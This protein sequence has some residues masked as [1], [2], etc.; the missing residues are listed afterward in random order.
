MR[1]ILLSL[2]QIVLVSG[3]LYSYYHFFLRNKRFH[4]YNRFF[5][6]AVIALSILIPFLNI[7]VYFTEQEA[8]SYFVLRTLNIVPDNG[9]GEEFT[10]AVILPEESRS[11]NYYMLLYYVYIGLSVL[12]LARI[13]ISLIKIHKLYRNNPVEK[14][15]GAD[16]ETIYFINTVEPGTPF[17]FFKW[18]FWNRDIELQSDKG[19]QIFRHEMFHIRQKHSWDTIF[20]EIAT[21]IFWI[22]PFFHIIKKEIKAIHEFLADKYAANE[23][24][25]W[26]YAELLLMQALHTNHSLVNPFFH[27]QIKRRIAMITSSNKPGHQYLRKILVLPLLALVAALFAFTYKASRNNND[28]NIPKVEGNKLTLVV[29]AGHGGIDAGALSRDGKFHESEITLQ[30]A[31]KIEELSSSYNI[32]VVLTRAQ[33]QLPGNAGNIKDGLV[34]RVQISKESKA[35][36]FLSLHLNAQQSNAKNVLTGFE[37]YIAKQ[38]NGTNSSPLASTV[39]RHLSAMYTTNDIVKVRS[40]DIYVLEHNHAPS[41][42]LE[43]GSITNANDLAFISNEANQEQV[44]KTI[45]AAITAWANTDRKAKPAPLPLMTNK[46]FADTPRATPFLKVLVNKILIKKDEKNEERV[47]AGENIS[48]FPD[49][50]LIINGKKY[51]PQDAAK[52]K[53]S[54]IKGEEMIITPAG[55]KK[56]I[57]LYGELA[58]N[59][60]IEFKDAYIIKAVPVE[61]VKPVEIQGLKSI[62]GN[63]LIVIDDEVRV[64]ADTVKFN[65]LNPDDIKSINILKN[66]SAIDKYGED[67][68]NGVIEIF[69]KKTLED[70]T[71][72]GKQTDKVEEVSKSNTQSKLDEVIV[73]GYAK[74]KSNTQSKLDEVV[75]TGYAKPRTGNGEVKEVPNS[76]TQSKLDE[77]VVTGYAKPKSNTQTKL[78][79]VVVTGYGKRNDDNIIFEKTEVEATFPGGEPAFRKY[80]ENN[81]DN[82]VA[83]R[84]GAPAGVYTVFVQF[85]VDKEGNIS[86]VRPLTNHGYGMEQEAVRLIK[87]GPKWIP[88]IQNGHKVKSYRRQP[89]N[90]ASNRGKSTTSVP[91]QQLPEVVFVAYSSAAPGTIGVSKSKLNETLPGSTDWKK[92]LERNINPNA[93]LLEPDRKKNSTRLM[94]K[95]AVEEDGTISNI[96]EMTQHAPRTAIHAIATIRHNINKVVNNDNQKKWYVQPLTFIV[97][98]EDEVSGIN[99]KNTSITFSK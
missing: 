83:E 35:D 39:L 76:N 5:L 89:I 36:V 82:S 54:I 37:A 95:F 55:D 87:Q 24:G 13:I 91:V 11:F 23:N 81:L 42:V 53:G 16:G 73:T 79:E 21:I 47:N 92:F 20:V 66:Q 90:F 19:E 84:N 58:V 25:K 59:G 32:D 72:V 60:V 27:N 96:Q 57:E 80:F 7:P 38:S 61:T 63:P 6:L 99:D 75:V 3:I 85:V 18:M 50:L 49:R 8:D 14:I 69:T 44:A 43:C 26:N 93:F 9:P 33:D 98:N 2:L 34:K 70:V 88:A 29:D 51:T 78:D 64:S 56:A 10:G 94:V 15:S 65:M 62:T 46:I 77:V 22:N 4:Q 1:S 48:V 97:Q 41:L 40:H 74:P 17:S 68:K 31:K 12:F 30:L 86:D 28:E 45:L 67:G 71:V 52:F